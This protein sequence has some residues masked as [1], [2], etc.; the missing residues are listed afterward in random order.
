MSSGANTNNSIALNQVS[1][2][3]DEGTLVYHMNRRINASTSKLN[4]TH[5]KDD[6]IYWWAN[7]SNVIRQVE[8]NNIFENDMTSKL[9]NNIKLN[10]SDES[11]LK[12]DEKQALIKSRAAY[13]V[14]IGLLDSKLYT[15]IKHIHIEGDAYGLYKALQ[16]K[17]EPQS[18]I[19]SF[20]AQQKLHSVK[21]NPTET[22]SELFNRIN[23]L[24]DEIARFPKNPDSDK[25]LALYQSI[26]SQDQEMLRQKLNSDPKY[27]F[28]Q[29]MQ[30]L[31]AEEDY[32]KL[33]KSKTIS[34]TKTDSTP[35]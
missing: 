18:A 19:T 4:N 28:Q 26:S 7:L 13:S 20:Q 21:M 12:D 29:A 16:N 33:N 9:I 15:T 31:L 25:L 22:Y 5:E 23:G 34:E 30:L 24:A 3:L 32:R 35:K 17:F 1:S 27:S 14:M 11:K 8:I 6:F 2:P 10:N